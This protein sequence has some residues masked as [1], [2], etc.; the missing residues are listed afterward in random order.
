MQALVWRC[1]CVFAIVGQVIAVPRSTR[2]RGSNGSM[3]INLFPRQNIDE[4]FDETDL[5]FI[6]K[7]SAIGDSYSAGIGAGD[8]LGSVVELF[9]PQSGKLLTLL[10]HFVT[11]SLM[12]KSRVFRLCL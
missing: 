3:P 10:D 12:L 11:L 1:L 6:K 5:S 4:D 2:Y 9:D 7:L 8:R